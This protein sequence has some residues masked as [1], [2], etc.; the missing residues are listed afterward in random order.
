MP[1]YTF[2]A[3]AEIG[4]YLGMEP[5]FVDCDEDYN[6]DLNKVDDLI[7]KEDII[8]A[9]I[10]VHFAGKPV[11]MNSLLSISEKYN[12]F[13]L[14][15]AA[16]ALETVSNVGKVGNTNHASAFSFYANKNITTAGEG[17]AVATN[18]KILANKIR[19]LSLHG[20]T[21]DGWNR[22]KLGKKWQ[23]DVSSLGYKYN[24]TDFAASFGQWQMDRLETWYDK[25]LTIVNYY[26]KIYLR[27]TV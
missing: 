13:I 23:Y 15:D 22:F 5:I 7:K 14:E 11:D 4:E 17:G 25:R 20:M 21:K 2:V 26:Q 3:S 6:L 10:P 9:I 12:I 24:M 1:T 18:D 8:K 16:H 27:L 19:Q